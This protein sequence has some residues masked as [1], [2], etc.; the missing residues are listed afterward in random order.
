[1]N[2]AIYDYGTGNLH[3]L[4]KA[5]EDAGAHVK[6]EEDPAIALRFDAL[7]LPGVGAFG[8]ASSRL[9]LHGPAL[10][11]AL[12]SGHPCLGICLGMQLLFDSSEEGEGAGIS[13]FRG[14]VSKLRARRTPHMGWN[15]VNIIQ[16]DPLFN[17]IP[18]MLAYYANSY[19]AQPN[20]DGSVLA[21]SEYERERF[22]AVVR[23]DRTWGVQFHPEKS[24]EAGLRL[25]RNFLA[26]SQS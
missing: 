1:V 25:I 20:G 18:E 13:A 6:V 23:R 22:P 24:G 11:A 7:V 17:G 12:A 2:V 3:S 10:R 16:P 4:A 19:V 5:F 21:W 26:A 9:S 14:R 8:A 15:D